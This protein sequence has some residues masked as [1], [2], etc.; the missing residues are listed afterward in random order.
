MNLYDNIKRKASELQEYIDVPIFVFNRQGDLIYTGDENF[1]DKEGFFDSNVEY[2]TKRSIF[3]YQNTT[4]NNIFNNNRLFL[5]IG[6]YGIDEKS[7]RLVMILT[8]LLEEINMQLSKDDFLFEL[9]LGNL[10]EE[11]IYYYSDKY[12]LDKDGLYNV[13]TIES[14]DI[15]DDAIKV[16]GHI[17][18]K[19]SYYAI[20]FNQHRFVI[21]LLNKENNNLYNEVKI[22]KD[23]IESEIFIKV[24]IGISNKKTVLTEI[25]KGY[26]EA[27]IALELGKKLNLNDNGLYFYEKYILG[28]LLTH[29]PQIDITKFLS[30]VS[31][32]KLSCFNDSEL[33]LTLNSFFKNSLN[34]SETS[35]DLYIHRNTLVYR[36]DKIHRITGLDPKNFDDALL[37]KIIM[38]LVRLH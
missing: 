5:T 10:D 28:E 14:S 34:L 38:I 2:I 21:C 12:K 19:N 4:F 32:D 37:L 35:R 36:L 31:I 27:K 24:N 9:L 8:K 18:D 26:N 22:I 1:I 20:R 15:I 23:T 11:E 33:V 7:S 3:K 17:F 16:V 13:I 6:V 25:D 29:I 30:K